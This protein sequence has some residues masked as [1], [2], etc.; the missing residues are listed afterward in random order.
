M[1][2]GS[3]EAIGSDG[4]SKAIRE[5]RTDSSIKAVVLRINSPGG[6]ALASEVIWREVE[7][8]KKV[9]PVIVSMGDVAASG[10][11][12]IACP[13]DVV[14]ANP[15][16]ITGSIGVF[17]VLWNGQ[18]FM[19][20]KLGITVDRV[21]TNTHSDI[22]SVF[23]PMTA[24]EKDVI[25]KS[26]EEI[27]DVFITHVSEGRKMTKAQVDSIG[28]G[29]VWSGSNAKEIGLVDEFG[30]IKKAIEIARIKANLDSAEFRIVQYPKQEDPFEQIVKQLTGEVRAS[31][32]Q[33]NLGQSYKYYKSLNNFLKLNGVQARMP[34]D[35]DIY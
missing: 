5:A 25:Q 29:R 16:T 27:Y 34:F 17:G 33:E 24:S 7:L 12:Y 13:A 2:E 19:N 35:V 28:Q 23:R 30:G 11:Y 1:G 6:S 15:N 10:G 9:K 3:D 32:I 4:L 22:G 21:T 18:K 20:D 31:F 8:T 14:V 26:V